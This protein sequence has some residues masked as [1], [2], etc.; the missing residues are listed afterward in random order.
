VN[1]PLWI[2]PLARA[3]AWLRVRTRAPGNLEGPVIFASNTRASWM[4]GDHGR[5][6][7][8]VALRGRAGDAQG[9][10]AAHFFPSQHTGASGCG[11]A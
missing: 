9:M 8:S 7:G 4:A 2:L 1:L 6:A 10:F 11:T 5:L 3:F